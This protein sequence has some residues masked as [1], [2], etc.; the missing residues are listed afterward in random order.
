MH[1]LNAARLSFLGL[2]KSVDHSAPRETRSND[3]EI[4]EF[5]NEGGKRGEEGRMKKKE[6][7]KRK[8]KPGRKRREKA[9]DDRR[10]R[11]LQGSKER[12]RERGRAREREWSS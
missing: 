4:S 8:E 9:G 3:G 2:A 11:L 10:R 6:E 5:L 1:R 7:K 12:E